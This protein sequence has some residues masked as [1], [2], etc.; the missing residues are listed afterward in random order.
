MNQVNSSYFTNQRL[1]HSQTRI[2]QLIQVKSCFERF[3]TFPKHFKG[4]LDPFHN[5]NSVAFLPWPFPMSRGCR[6]THMAVTIEG[7]RSRKTHISKPSTTNHK[8]GS[9]GLVSY[10]P[11]NK[12]YNFPYLFFIFQLQIF[13][14]VS[15]SC[16]TSGPSPSRGRLCFEGSS[17]VSSTCN[18]WG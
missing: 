14:S 12:N 9:F 15:K 7:M 1:P 13:G 16:P 3:P 17:Q 8:D 2:D 4:F 6:I 18:C 10:S 5:K 11:N